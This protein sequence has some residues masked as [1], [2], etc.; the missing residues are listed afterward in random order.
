LGEAPVTAGCD[1]LTL[2]YYLNMPTGEEA[3]RLYLTY[4]ADPSKLR[5]DAKIKKLSAAADRT[6][7]NRS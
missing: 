4:L 3:V 1:N 6:N 5:D 7:P 2:L